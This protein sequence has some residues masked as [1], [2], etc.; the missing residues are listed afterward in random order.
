MNPM[1]R[2]NISRT[3]WDR[4]VFG[5]ETYEIIAHGNG[6]LNPEVEALV[7]NPGHYTLK[8]NPLS[9][10]EDIQQLGFYYVDTLIEPFCKESDFR[11]HSH[12]SAYL[13]DQMTSKELEPLVLGVFKH[14]R[15]HRDFN[16]DPHLSDLRYLN[17]ASQLNQSGQLIGLGFDQNL[18]G[19]FAFDKAKILLHSILPTYQGKGLG[20]YLWTPACQR[21]FAQGNSEIYSSVSTANLAI[22]NLYISLGFKMRNPLDVYHKMV[23]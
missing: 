5:V 20:K 15:F 9:S 17:W 14:G 16:L 21:L 11:P 4:E 19:F 1:I 6:S 12:P 7:Q 22:V 8:V 23:K 2:T 3:P 18:I 10:K 13:Q